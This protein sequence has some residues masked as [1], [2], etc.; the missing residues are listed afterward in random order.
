M[1]NSRKPHHVTRS[2][3]VDF[4]HCCSKSF[5]FSENKSNF[6]EK[7]LILCDPQI[8]KIFDFLGIFAQKRGV[9]KGLRF[10][11]TTRYW[12]SSE[13]NDIEPSQNLDEESKF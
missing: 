3:T 5:G 13:K 4:Q 2:P 8:S 10:R 6:F 9:E 7:I 12:L 1:E 11:R